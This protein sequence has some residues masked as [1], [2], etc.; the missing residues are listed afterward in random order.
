M[1][2]VKYVN[3]LVKAAGKI[4]NDFIMEKSCDKK[5]SNN[6]IKKNH[7]LKLAKFVNEF[8]IFISMCS[9]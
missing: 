2:V 8:I 3:L 9:I 6:F 4:V 7:N 1:K 5:C